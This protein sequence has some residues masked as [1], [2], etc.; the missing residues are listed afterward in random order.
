ML[1]LSEI[2]NCVSRKFHQSLGSRF[3]LRYRVHQL[4]SIVNCF[5]LVRRPFWGT[6][7]DSTRGQNRKTAQVDLLCPF[8]LQV[9][10]EKTY[11]D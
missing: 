8:R 1:S 2:W 4:V 7:R 5:K 11:D 10:V 6:P 9:V 3:S